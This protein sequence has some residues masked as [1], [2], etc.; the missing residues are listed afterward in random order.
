M[1]LDALMQAISNGDADEVDRVIS[2]GADVSSVR[3]TQHP[4]FFTT[5]T[6]SPL[7]WAAFQS[8]NYPEASSHRIFAA[9]LASGA[10][11][12]VG[13]AILFA[14]TVWSIEQ[15]AQAGAP[16]N[17]TMT[18]GNPR[19]HGATALMFRAEAS[20]L[21]SVDLLVGLGADGSLATASGDT[22]LDYAVRGDKPV[23]VDADVVIR[24][25]LVQSLSR[26]SPPL[27]AYSQ[28]MLSVAQ[29]DLLER[30]TVVNPGPPPTEENV[31]NRFPV[32]VRPIME[33]LE[34][35]GGAPTG[36][37]ENAPER[38]NILMLMLAN[39]AFRYEPYDELSWLCRRYGFSLIDDADSS[40]APVLF[41]VFNPARLYP[42][43]M[44][45]LVKLARL[46]IAYNANLNFRDNSGAT[47]LHRIVR[48]AC[49]PKGSVSPDPFPCDAGAGDAACVLFRQ[50][51]DVLVAAGAD[52]KLTDFSGRTPG[53]EARA[54]PNCPFTHLPVRSLLEG[55]PA[56]TL[57][58]DES[59]TSI[60]EEES[61][62]IGEILSEE[63]RELR[64]DQQVVEGIEVDAL[65]VRQSDALVDPAAMPPERDAELFADAL[66]T[67]DP[68][69]T[70]LDPAV[71]P[72]YRDANQKYVGSP[73]HV[74]PF[75]RI[76]PNNGRRST[77]RQAQLYEQYIFYAFYEGPGPYPKANRPGKSKHEY[78]YA[79]D[80]IRS[81]DE[82]RL[83][84]AL[85]T[86]GW[87]QT[88]ED[89]GWHW[90]ATGAPRYSA[91][92]TFIATEMDALSEQW[93][94]TL[95]SFYERRKESLVLLSELESLRLELARTQKNAD[96]LR[97]QLAQESAW[98]RNE[99]N[100]LRLEYDEILSLDKQIVQLQYERANKRYTYCPNGQPY[101]RC[102][103]Y[104]LKQRYDN[105]LRQL[106]Q[107]IVA[108]RTRRT[109]LAADY[110]TGRRELANRRQRYAI[111][112]R[113]WK[114]QL[115]QVNTLQGQVAAKRQQVTT[116]QNQMQAA[117]TSSSSQLTII[118]AKVAG[119]T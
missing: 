84:D 4:R 77:I 112:E 2:L 41:H 79:I 43:F 103:H 110:D 75:I 45:E 48:G 72:L 12:S 102:E 73:G 117:R 11:A 42:R 99:E 53:R 78:G 33:V 107:T 68:E 82:L 86:S 3:Q 55:D 109:Q 96:D 63:L 54:R 37:F 71:T 104:D 64:E 76:N 94:L 92:D 89:E 66:A 70:R 67:E 57:T 65:W 35:F 98:L 50:A 24:V 10:D 116:K 49:R 87:T 34:S 106:D 6:M 31:Y 16:V 5:T 39:R 58:E 62:P 97:Q 80:V 51:S 59:L 19:E 81:N 113:E 61:S 93:A 36:I 27:R 8:A 32:S 40:G 100:R 7:G 18:D 60:N 20:D 108:M 1:P 14:S 88:V 101:E 111:K 46:F 38:R 69:A 25:E 52:P 56:E 47:V 17:V 13:K 15:L 95:S 22:A 85:S 118:A 29:I 26:S 44:P 21:P 105:E 28:A 83:A 23:K 74:D 30:K 90:E 115:Q 119:W 9:L 91:L 114:A